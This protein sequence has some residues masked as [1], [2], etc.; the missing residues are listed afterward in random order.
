MKAPAPFRKTRRRSPRLT[1]FFLLL[2]SP[3]AFPGGAGAAGGA[4]VVGV[5][6]LVEIAARIGGDEIPVVPLFP[7][8]LHP[9]SAAPGMSALEGIDGPLFYLKVSDLLDGLSLREARRA[10]GAALV[11]VDLARDIDLIGEAAAEKAERK[12]FEA[13]LGIDGIEGGGR[14]GETGGVV[15][16]W[17]D[18]LA[19]GKAALTIAEALSEAMPERGE[20]F[21]RRA[22]ALREELTALDGAERFENDEFHAG[23]AGSLLGGA[24]GKEGV[25]ED[26]SRAGGP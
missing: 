6:P 21:R 23:A 25:G 17:L 19:V 22:D 10:A 8:G 13:A 15:T 16:W 1:A 26:G 9:R 20:L 7:A 3:L 18:P 24:P 5:S 4:I 12:I 14:A 2:F 11:T